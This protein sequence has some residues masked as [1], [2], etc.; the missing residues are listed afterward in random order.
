M[1]T[2][3][4]TGVVPFL[5]DL[6]LGGTS[7]VIAKTACA[8]LERV[9]ILLQVQSASA[10]GPKY[11]GFIDTLTRVPKEEGISALW[12]G[13]LA[14]CLRYFPTQAMNFAFKEKYQKMFVRPREEVGFG[15]WFAGF[16]AA[17]AAAG[18]TALTVSYP[19]E[20]TYTRL[21][22]DSGAHGPA[23]AAGATGA[24]AA[25]AAP[26]RQYTGMMDCISKTV[27]SDGIRGLY[28]GYGPSVAGIIVY[29]AGYFGLYDFS[30]AYVMP[31]ITTDAHSVS[32]I[33]TKFALALTIDI[34]SAMA[35]YP[36][37]TVRR[38]MMMMSGRADRPFTTSY[39]CFRYILKNSG[40]AGLYKG[41]F[42]NSV[43]AIG[44]ALVLVLYDELRAVFIP[45]AASKGH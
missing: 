43:R 38:S 1:S 24:A 29:R 21:A 36:L 16:L 26:K 2:E 31:H 14:N 4:K 18:A 13:N 19:L 12:R 35:S 23:P 15:R 44:S 30:K 34:F 42:T 41:A 9:K 11:N 8:P 32:T 28:R 40:A 10:S 27:K 7:G 37:D 22:A 25:A 45:G 6:A 39:G 20:Y 3:K 5:Q 33:L 17:G